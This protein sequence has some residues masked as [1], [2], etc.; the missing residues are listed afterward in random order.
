M[1]VLK[2]TGRV[3]P[4]GLSGKVNMIPSST[5]GGP[6]QSKTVDPKHVPVIVSPDEDYYG[7]AVVNIRAVPLL[8]FCEAR[9]SER[10]VDDTV[11]IVVDV[12]SETE[13]DEILPGAD[14][15][16]NHKQ[17]P[18]L[19][20]EMIENYPYA[21]IVLSAHDD[22][23]LWLSTEKMYVSTTDG[24]N[25]L[26][27]P[28]DRLYYGFN[29]SIWLAQYAYTTKGSYNIK[30][31]GHWVVWWANHDIHIGSAD[32]GEIY[33]PASQ[34]QEVQ[35]ADATHFYYNGVRLPAIPEKVLSEYPYAFIR[36]DN[37]SG[38]YDLA[39]SKSVF[40]HN[41]DIHCADGDS[42]IQKWYQIPITTAD[43][44]TAWA[45]KEDTYGVWV[46]NE[47]RHMVWSNH[48]IPNGSATATEI[49]HYSNLAVPA[50]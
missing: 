16:Y 26:N 34:P 9:I 48:D 6:L 18:E 28:A 22:F 12:H 39:L 45:F 42:A 23:W 5:Q 3:K 13:V 36:K 31:S 1:N 2:L 29:A 7:L 25:K 32:S 24:V 33:F 40:Y 20:A 8:P 10:I 50:D 38:Y 27:I 19:R 14:Y 43:S 46:I 41:T 44:M 11:K 35:P 4:I 30:G 17:L 21:A 49:Y 37:Y 47:N 15:Y